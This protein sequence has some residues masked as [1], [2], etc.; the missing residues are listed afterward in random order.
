MGNRTGQRFG[1]YSVGAHVA[2]GS[3]GAVYE[4]LN[5]ETEERVA[6]KVLHP[7]VARD[8]VAAARF[9]REYDTAKAF[10][11]P[12]IIDVYDFGETNDRAEYM[13]ME[14]LEGEE[15]SLILTRDAPMPPARV[16]RLVCQIALAL[17]HAHADGVIHR[18]LKPDNIFVCSGEAGDDVR[19][20]DFGSVKL[21]VET[22]PKLTMLGTTLGS[23]YYMSPEQAM[24][25]ADID[26]RTDVFAL[27]AIMYEL[28]TAE[29]AFDGD[30][31]PEILQKLIS[32]EPPPVSIANSDYPWAF[33]RV[34]SKG[35]HKDKQERFGSSID[36]AEGMLQA[37][38]LDADVERWSRATTEEIEEAI[39]DAPD[40]PGDVTPSPV[41]EA[42]SSFP[43][44][45][46]IRE[47][48]GGKLLAGLFLLAALLLGLWLLLS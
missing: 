42:E 14:F 44:E 11:H 15:L 32:H 33:D 46:P 36:L 37:F 6:I 20:L 30:Q 41:P 39:A 4:A 22:G 21:Q 26:P 48:R 28:A 45:L 12:H 31:I 38:G 34:V 47:N 5:N 19:I 13:A 17:Q 40:E 16:L 1:A 35:L 18:D 43:S 3:M 27:A 7:K 23:P 8:K 9:R 25:R 2:D 24:G 10:D 29:V